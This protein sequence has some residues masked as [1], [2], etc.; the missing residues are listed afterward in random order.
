[1]SEEEQLKQEIQKLQPKFMIKLTLK[2]IVAMELAIFKN[3]LTVNANK[4]SKNNLPNLNFKHQI[5]TGIRCP[6]NQLKHQ[7]LSV[8]YFLG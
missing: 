5:K 4:Q 3:V 6:I 2:V 1:M 7:L 8:Q